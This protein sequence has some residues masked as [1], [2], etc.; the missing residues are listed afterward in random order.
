[1]KRNIPADIPQ[2]EKSYDHIFKEI[3]ETF[4]SR[5]IIA[6]LNSVFKHNISLNSAV[7]SMRTESNIGNRTIADYI[8]KV[9]EPSGIIRYFHIE[10]Q[11]SNDRG[12]AFRMVEYGIRFALERAKNGTDKDEI[13]IEFPHA[14]VFYLKDNRNTPRVLNVTVKAPDGK[15]LHYSIPTERMSDYT[16]EELLEQEKYPLFPFYMANFTGKDPDKFEREWLA[17]CAKLNEFVKSG[18]I[19]KTEADKLLESGSIVVKKVNHPNEKQ[20]GIKSIG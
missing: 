19:G 1:M 5:Y 7:E 4:P 9:T 15:E 8:L 20:S 12:M 18:R 16:P 3:L 11:T 2:K 6:F 13:L 10:A 17:G 14:A